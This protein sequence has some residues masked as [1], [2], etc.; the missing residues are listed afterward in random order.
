MSE[1]NTIVVLGAALAGLPLAHWLMKHSATSNNKLKVVLVA[2]NTHFYWNLASV[3]GIVPDQLAD[4]RLFFP[5]APTF[6]QYPAKDRFEFIVGKAQTLDPATRTVKVSL[7]EGGGERVVTYNTLIIA[8]GASFR[9]DLPFKNLE[10]TEAT[11][12][13]LHSLQNAI[14]SA[15]SIVVAGAGHTGSEI[16]GELGEIYASKGLKEITVIAESSL[17]LATPATPSVRQ[18]LAA[19]LKAMK[20]NLITSARVTSVTDAADGKGKVLVVTKEDGT[21][22]TINT[23]VYLP[24]F[25]VVPNSQFAPKDMLDASG[26]FKQTNELKVEGH[27]D[28]FVVGDAGNLQPATAKT[29]EEQITHM[30]KVFPALLSGQKLPPYK[31]D[32][33]VVFAVSLGRNGGIG[34]L[35]TFKLFSIAVKYA[36][37]KYLGTDYAGDMAAGKRTVMSKSW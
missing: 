31:I 15:K 33:K 14:K 3:R 7:N 22:E 9:G 24:A 32:T 4:D 21:K 10:S 17:P 34:Q 18:S 19:S 37:S 12:A 13:S 5:I 30:S 25:G 27:D 2:P 1:S 16:A 29:V 35:G 23:D 26:F 20:I 6:A 36:K 28:I 11:K 8:T